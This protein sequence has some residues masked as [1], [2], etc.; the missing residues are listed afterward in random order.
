MKMD[1]FI[2]SMLQLII[3]TSNATLEVPSQGPCKFLDIFIHM[4][5]SYK[6][7]IKRFIEKMDLLKDFKNGTVKF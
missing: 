2:N 6:K 1:K 3:S 5:K 7:F 4:K